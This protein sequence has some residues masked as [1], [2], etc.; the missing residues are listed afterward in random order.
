MKATPSGL[1]VKD[2]ADES[3]PSLSGAMQL[4][5]AQ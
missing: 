1:G 3:N 4:I 5:V 2:D